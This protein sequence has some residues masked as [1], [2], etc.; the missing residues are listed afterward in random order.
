MMPPEKAQ[1]EFSAIARPMSGSVPSGVGEGRARIETGA[2]KGSSEPKADDEE[3][4]C[5]RAAPQF[6]VRLG[7]SIAAP[8]EEQPF[9]A[10]ALSLMG[11]SAEVQTEKSV[12]H[13]PHSAT[14]PMVTLAE[15]DHSASIAMRKPM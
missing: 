7:F 1:A 15:R 9:V 4:C 8:S 5:T 6:I 10:S 11:R 14:M 2:A 13:C 12:F 3:P